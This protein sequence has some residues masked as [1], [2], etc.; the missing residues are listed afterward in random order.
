MRFDS[1]EMIIS[2]HEKILNAT[3]LRTGDLTEAASVRCFTRQGSATVGVDFT[4][5]PNTEVSRVVFP[6]G[7]L[8]RNS[9][10][11]IT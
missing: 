4:E 5:R 9:L 11:V 1:A 10:L 6:P 7:K 2:E 3:I 8:L